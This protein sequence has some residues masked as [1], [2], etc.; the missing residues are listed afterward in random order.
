MGWFVSLDTDDDAVYIVL[1]I[2]A[3]Y[4]R[5]ELVTMTMECDLNCDLL[6]RG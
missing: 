2:G 4:R 1:D 3:L 6:R 5:S